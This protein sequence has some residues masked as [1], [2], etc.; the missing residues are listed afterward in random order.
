[1]KKL[2]IFCSG[3][4]L[5]APLVL[6]ILVGM[7]VLQERGS[8]LADRRP[9]YVIMAFAG[10]SGLIVA[11]LDTIKQTQHTQNPTEK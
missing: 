7:G 9:L 6:E 1:M 3:L 4:L 2:L 8:T 11:A 10:I 5:L